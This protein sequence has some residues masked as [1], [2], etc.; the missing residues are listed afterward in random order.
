MFIDLTDAF[1][2]WRVDICDYKIPKWGINAMRLNSVKDTP[3]KYFSYCRQPETTMDAK[4]RCKNKVKPNIP[5]KPPK[6]SSKKRNIKIIDPAKYSRQK[7]T[8]NQLEKGIPIIFRGKWKFTKDVKHLEE[9]L[10]CSNGT[11][12]YGV[13]LGENLNA[14]NQVVKEATSGLIDEDHSR[15][16]Q[17]MIF[18]AQEGDVFGSPLHFD[19]HCYPSF[20]IQYS[21]RKRWSLWSPSWYL[22]KIKPHTR[23]EVEMVPGDILYWGPGWF[24]ETEVLEGSSLAVA[25]FIDKKPYSP[26][27]KSVFQEN[28]FGFGGCNFG[29]HIKS[30]L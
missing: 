6:H 22:G 20:S 24:H 9:Q 27:M 18:A 5:H 2:P 23:Y 19:C 1:V 12:S 4:N 28:P 8:T 25:W 13:Q 29:I 7:F 3:T 11:C 10:N 14:T 16:F 21:G 17:P 15:I 26:H 30:E